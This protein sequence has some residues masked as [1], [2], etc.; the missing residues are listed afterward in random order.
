MRLESGAY[1]ERTSGVLHTLFVLYD[2][3]A[4]IYAFLGS[5]PGGRDLRNVGP[6]GKRMLVE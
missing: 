3:F 4:P 1:E 2:L 5:L 6:L